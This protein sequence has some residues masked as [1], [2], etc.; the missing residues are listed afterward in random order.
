M[1]VALDKAMHVFWKNGYEGTSLPDLT[2]AMGINRPSLYAAFGNKEM[3]FRKAVDR[4]VQ[5]A[6][7]WLHA[8]MAQP[9]ARAAVEHLLM[10]SIPKE[11]APNIGG[12]MLVQGALVC[13]ESADAIKKDLAL[14]RRATEVLLRQ[15]FE[16]AIEEH[17]LSTGVDAAA[18]AKY[19]AT[20]QQGLA[21]QTSSGAARGEL[22]GAVQIAMQA[23]PE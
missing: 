5:L 2:A 18:L 11:N 21:V 3:L 14:R 20:F 10:E 8:A 16:R 6:G 17:D 22:L 9:T 4:Y 7:C 12:C 19:F 1:E 15:R 23:W 13:S